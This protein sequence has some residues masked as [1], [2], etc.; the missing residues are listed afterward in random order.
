M[1]RRYLIGLV[2]AVLLALGPTGAYANG[3]AKVKVCH[4]PP[5][6]PSNFYTITISVLAMRTL[7]ELI[8][9]SWP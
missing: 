8:C 1:I 9:K 4:A 3:S 7:A 5:D 2:T 6:N